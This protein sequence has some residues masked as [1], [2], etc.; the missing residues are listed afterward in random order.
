MIDAVDDSD[1]LDSGDNL[2]PTGQVPRLIAQGINNSDSDGDDSDDSMTTNMTDLVVTVMM[3]S[4]WVIPMKV[5][6]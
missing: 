2:P 3:M 6:R 4:Q 1:T 5:G